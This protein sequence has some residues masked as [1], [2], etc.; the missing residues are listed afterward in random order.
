MAALGTAG[1]LFSF[2]GLLTFPLKGL[3]MIFFLPQPLRSLH[4]PLMADPCVLG[5]VDILDCQGLHRLAFRRV[6]QPT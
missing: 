4:S 3:G 1:Q 6:Y 5:T 2:C